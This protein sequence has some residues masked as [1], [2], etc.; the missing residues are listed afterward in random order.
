MFEFEK[1]KKK[2][3]KKKTQTKIKP[4]NEVNDF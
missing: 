2:I 3:N 4:H 1:R